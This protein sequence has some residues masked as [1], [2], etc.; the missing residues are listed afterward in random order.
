MPYG[1]DRMRRSDFMN[2]FLGEALAEARRRLERWR[3]EDLLGSLRSRPRADRLGDSFTQ[4]IRRDDTIRLIAEFK[5]SSPSGGPFSAN[6]DIEDRARAYVE[7]GG[8]AVSVL[9]EPRWFGGSLDDL[10]AV[11]R[12]V[13]VPILRKDFI[14]EEYDLEV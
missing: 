6:V 12:I 8:A 9:T 3:L 10:I 2:G 11:R 5:R 13:Q 7:G 14:V 1:A 4:A